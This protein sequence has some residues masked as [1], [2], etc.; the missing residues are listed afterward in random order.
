MSLVA[1]GEGKLYLQPQFDQIPILSKVSLKDAQTQ[2]N[3]YDE[4]ISQLD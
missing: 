4:V 3:F 2:D 1:S